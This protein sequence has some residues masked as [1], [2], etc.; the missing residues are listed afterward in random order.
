MGAG[1]KADGGRPWPCRERDGCRPASARERPP[2]TPRWAGGRGRRSALRAPVGQ[3]RQ[4]IQQGPTFARV[5][6]AAVG[7]QHQRPRAARDQRLGALPRAL[8]R[9]DRDLVERRV[10]AGGRAR[11]RADQS[12]RSPVLRPGLPRWPPAPSRTRA[13]ASVQPSGGA[14]RSRGPTR[15]SSTTPP[16]SRAA[17]LPIEGLV[18]EQRLRIGGPQEPTSPPGSAT[19]SS[20][21]TSAPTEVPIFWRRGHTPSADRNGAAW[22]RRRGSQ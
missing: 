2:G 21:S 20:W 18:G 7:G 3:P 11:S 22:L 6:T 10:A 16:P 14:P 13:R 8:Q 1:W 19:I 9:L 15:P 17:L 12:T 5:V 4:Q